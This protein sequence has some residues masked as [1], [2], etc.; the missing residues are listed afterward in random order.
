MLVSRELLGVT[1]S[2]QEAVERIPSRAL[3]QAGRVTMTAALRR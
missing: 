2:F 3:R 1:Q